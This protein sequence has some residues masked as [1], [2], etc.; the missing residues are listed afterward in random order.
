M[1]R[2]VTTFIFIV[3]VVASAMG[4]SSLCASCHVTNSSCHLVSGLFTK[5]NLPPGYN[6]ITIL[7][8]GSC[9]V[10]ISFLNHNNNHFAL[11]SSND[12]YLID[13]LTLSGTYFGAGTEFLYSRG[14]AVTQ[15]RLTADGPLEE[16][17]KLELFVSDIN[18]GVEYQYIIP[19][20]KNE[21]SF[22]GRNIYKQHPGKHKKRHSKQNYRW[23]LKTLTQCTN[24]CG[25][26]Y[27]RAVAIC[28]KTPGQ[29]VVP[30]RKC[31]ERSKPS[32]R[33]VRCNR[34]PCPG[35]WVAGEWG[36]CSTSC[37]EG[38]QTRRVA[39]RQE[40]AEGLSIPVTK[41]LCQDSHNMITQRKCY[42]KA[43][44]FNE[45]QDVILATQAGKDTRYIYQNLQPK[46]VNTI[47][48]FSLRRNARKYP[49]QSKPK[50]VID[51]SDIIS[52]T[53]IAQSWGACSVSCGSG[54]KER[55]VHC[56]DT[57]GGLV[58][59]ARC[60]VMSR[61]DSD[62]FCNAGP[63]VTNTW[64]ISQWGECSANCGAGLV[65]RRVICIG[66][67][68]ET[69]RPHT[70]EDC[71]ADHPCQGEWLSGRWSPCSHS[72]GDGVQSRTVE[73]S[74]ISE[75]GRR[76]VPEVSCAG[77]RKPKVER[78]CHH[79]ACMGE[80][81]TGDWGECSEVCGEGK[82]KREVLCL[83][84]NKTSEDCKWKNR[85]ETEMPCK[86]KN[87][88]G[89]E[90]DEIF[91]YDE[92]MSNEEGSGENNVKLSIV[93]EPIRTTTEVPDK[94]NDISNNEIVPEK[95]WKMEKGKGCQDRFKNCNVVVQSRL[96]KYSFYQTNCCRS[97]ALISNL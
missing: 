78:R 49:L 11:K 38:I 89:Y 12:V 13:S 77:R 30:D 87:C 18:H 39:C 63:C 65:Y 28:I 56:V 20:T 29:R 23:T 36:S 92:G 40:L 85:P 14:D 35:T 8:Q 71:Q 7:P 57:R 24:S 10:N 59:D 26:G 37:G 75:G 46:D 27:Q 32:E 83:A 95:H 44:K 64:L 62:A 53:W 1:I 47:G 91:E 6:L 76:I 81:F 22:D 82:K 61:P 21:L 42:V 2:A 68:D 96:C 34:Q 80:W 50:E 88:E 86:E 94:N 67:C 58:P 66:E 9:S 17:V 48:S 52:T 41:E 54:L 45:G 3:G 73:C 90:K 19:A 70:Q 31:A 16:S 25:G 84:K 43:C 69:I 15:E 5:P 55:R 60:N 93:E 4:S 74:M 33:S 72:C 51:E 97:C 79:Q